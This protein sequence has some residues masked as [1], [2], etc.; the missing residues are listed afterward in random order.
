MII[1]L[2][3]QMTDITIH[4][5][6]SCRKILRPNNDF[7]PTII[8]WYKRIHTYLQLIQMKEGKM[9]N[10]GNIL[11]FAWRQHINTSKGL[12]MEELQDGLRFARIRRAELRKQARGLRKVHLCNCLVDAIEKNQKKRTA[13]IKQRINQEESKR[14]WY[15][16]KRMVKDPQSPSVLKV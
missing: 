12:A 15:L 11:Q 16:I 4:T 1:K 3:K 7:S 2:Y 8:M 10:T 14:M 5:K 6:K 13:A 9:N